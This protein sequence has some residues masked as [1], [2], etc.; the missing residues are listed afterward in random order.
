VGEGIGDAVSLVGAGRGTGAAGL[1]GAGDGRAVGLPGAGDGRAVGLPGAGDGRAMGGSPP[2]RDGGLPAARA[3]PED[4]NGEA[5][6]PECCCRW[7]ALAWPD[8]AAGAPPHP[9]RATPMA[10]PSTQPAA[11]PGRFLD[12]VTC[13]S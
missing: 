10:A 11:V 5:V 1:P 4:G 2:A 9:A 7:A 3:G 12:D 6:L 13:S 8:T